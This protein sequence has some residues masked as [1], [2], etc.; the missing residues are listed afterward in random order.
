[1]FLA[2]ETDCIK[3]SMSGALWR[4]RWTVGDEFKEVRKSDVYSCGPL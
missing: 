3:V 2:E 1:M 4:K